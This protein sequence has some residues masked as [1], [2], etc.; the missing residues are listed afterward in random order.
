MP[1]D[2]HMSSWL[3]AAETADASEGLYL[4]VAP[5]HLLCQLLG[6]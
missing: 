2:G 4:V 3:L 6:A 1:S 5:E